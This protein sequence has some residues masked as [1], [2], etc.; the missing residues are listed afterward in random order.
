MTRWNEG[1]V[2]PEQCLHEVHGDADILA[3]TPGGGAD[4]LAAVAGSRSQIEAARPH[5][6]VVLLLKSHVEGRRRLGN[7]RRR[8]GG[9]RQLLS[10]PFAQPVEGGYN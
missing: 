6:G 2:A 9:F 7:G 4:R 3:A 5:R 10:P 1:N 8:G